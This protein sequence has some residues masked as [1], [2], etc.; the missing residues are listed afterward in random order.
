MLDVLWQWSTIFTVEVRCSLYEQHFGLMCTK[1]TV[2]QNVSVQEKTPVTILKTTN[3]R[4]FLEQKLDYSGDSWQ[5][6]S[7]CLG[8]YRPLFSLATGFVSIGPNYNFP[9]SMAEFCS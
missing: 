9:A 8:R 4:W 3:G 7:R 5:F 2:A 1:I 6:I